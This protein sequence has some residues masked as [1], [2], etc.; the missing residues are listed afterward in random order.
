MQDDTLLAYQIGFDLVENELQSFLTKVEAHLETRHAAASAA[1]AAFIG[2]A[3]TAPGDAMDADQASAEQLAARLEKM[4]EILGGKVA[5]GLY[6]NF[7]FRKNKADV[8]VSWGGGGG[9]ALLTDL[10]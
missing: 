2:D 4:K 10:A 7:L 5:V 8:Q 9:R 3:A 6:L 1:A